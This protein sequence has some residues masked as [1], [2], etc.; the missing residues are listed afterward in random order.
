MNTVPV[1]SQQGSE[2]DCGSGTRTL[3]IDNYDSYTYNL[4]QLF[5]KVNGGTA[6]TV[7]Y[8]NDDWPTV[9]AALL[10]GEYD[11][12]VLSPG[13]GTPEK[14]SDIGMC[15]SLL[16]DEDIAAYGVPI[17]GV[18]LGL[19]TLAHVHGGR[20]THGHAPM[21]GR[22]VPIQHDGK[23]LFEGLPDGY[24]AVRYNS[25]VVDP[26]S[27]PD[28]LEVS[29]WSSE[30][31]AKEVMGLRHR[32]RPIFTVQYHPES[33]CTQFGEKLAAN[34][35]RL[36]KAARASPAAAS[37]SS[38]CST[39]SSSSSSSSSSFVPLPHS[40]L[41]ATPPNP[42][43][44][45]VL[46]VSLSAALLSQH[47]PSLTRSD[48]CSVFEGPIF[49]DPLTTY[50]VLFKDQDS[51][52]WLDSSKV[53]RGLSRYSYMGA[54]DLLTH[55]LSPSFSGDQPSS[56]RV[57]YD[58]ST[59][60]VHAESRIGGKSHH[61]LPVG[62]T[63]FSLMQELLSSLS[64]DPS[65]HSSPI[66]LPFV[67]GF[68]GYFGYELKQESMSVP[69]DELHNKVTSPF[70][71]AQFLFVS[72]LIAFDHLENK[73]YFVCRGH[74]LEQAEAAARSWAGVVT[75]VVQ[76]RVDRLD[77]EAK[78]GDEHEEHT[79]SA[80]ST[81]PPSTS[82]CS[83]SS[84]TPLSPSVTSSPRSE[85]PIPS[86]ATSVVVH[87]NADPNSCSTPRLTRSRQQ[88]SSGTPDDAALASEMERKLRH[89]RVAYQER[90]AKAQAYIVDGE[91]Y[92]L[93]LTNQ[94]SDTLDGIEPFDLYSELRR[95]NPAPYAAYMR[96]GG[97]LSIACSSPER[98]LTI[99]SR[100]VVESKPIKG[101]RSRGATPEEDEALK[102]DLSQNAKDFAENLMIVDL[103][104][105][106]IGRVCLPGSVRVPKLM[107]V[108]TYATVHQ[109]VSTVQ[110]DLGTV[111][112]L[113]CVKSMFPPGSMTGAPKRRS[114]ELLDS[115]EEGHRGIYSGTLGY[116]SL[117]GCVD[118]NVVIRT[119]VCCPEE[120][121]LSI[122]TGG[123]IIYL[124]DVSDEFDEILL[125]A[126][127]LARS[128]SAV[129]QARLR[130]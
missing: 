57:H 65:L 13:P 121:S 81:S 30:D 22:V 63:F 107:D 50:E 66:D 8:N 60:T 75:E 41:T 104:R 124:S 46:A 86:P 59:R 110:G 111:P 130:R 5:F 76:S 39:S 27:I 112:A 123:A 129:K 7:V 87:G 67:G 97:S 125:K 95:C 89:G 64:Y 29:A 100:G 99:N 34:F 58:L 54:A 42:S 61:S 71:D 37:C 82:S 28:C 126:R 1:S 77:V 3:I 69:T 43:P 88:N 108:E 56:F 93:C 6:P 19:Q 17:L 31:G 83:A 74:S 94:L 78:T 73:T 16:L 84:T 40:T 33:I 85:S 114:V 117:N 62:C 72:H 49:L 25:L 80:A 105:N 122:G 68:A 38:L 128:I 45:P 116:L 115:L 14:S 119:A 92:E 32:S 127:A 98:F 23:G 35:I 118:L 96:F 55:S 120:D 91:S 18:C 10:R 90:I 2:S 51:S 24:S 53:E 47:A 102:L 48:V 20:V 26:S 106:D 11:H 12:V 4:Y 9:K 101:T 52:F 113:E 109:L 79:E 70:A 44:C 21:H 36:S 15:G 103:I